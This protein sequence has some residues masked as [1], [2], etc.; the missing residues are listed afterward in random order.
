MNLSTLYSDKISS[1]IFSRM[2][3]SIENTITLNDPFLIDEKYEKYI[4]S[5]EETI[6]LHGNINNIRICIFIFL[7]E[8]GIINKI[9]YNT[10][11]KRNSIIKDYMENFNTELI[12]KSKDKV[13]ID[14]LKSVNLIM[15][16]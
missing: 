6:R 15:I 8:E 2:Q 1:S 3:N 5:D 9:T 16:Q 10:C 14:Y 4:Y 7:N 13:N 12:G 11:N